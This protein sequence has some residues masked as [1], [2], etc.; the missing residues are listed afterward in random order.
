MLFSYCNLLIINEG[1]S[2]FCL[3]FTEFSP[4]YTQ[5]KCLRVKYLYAFYKTNE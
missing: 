5:N 3:L 4:S 2:R 1:F